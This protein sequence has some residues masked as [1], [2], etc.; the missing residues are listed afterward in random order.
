MPLTLYA[1]A[2]AS[3]ERAKTVINS[4]MKMMSS[5]HNNGQLTPHNAADASG[6]GLSRRIIYLAYSA[7]QLPRLMMLRADVRRCKQDDWA[8]A[9]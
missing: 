9:A 2:G 7:R 1:A 8:L 6:A 5:Q 4:A 3:D